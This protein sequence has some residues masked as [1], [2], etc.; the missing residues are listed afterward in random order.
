MK[1]KWGISVGLILSL[2]SVV[3]PCQLAAETALGEMILTGAATV[4]HVKA[5]S[6]STLFSGS[7]IET[8][9]PG[10]A[11]I[12][13]R[14]G[15]GVLALEPNS[16]VRLAGAPHRLTATV[17]QGLVTVRAKAPATVATPQLRIESE[18]ESA[19]QVAVTRERTEVVALTRTVRVRSNGTSVIVRPGERYNSQSGST[20][21]ATT[22]QDQSEASQRKRRVWGIL[23]PLLIG[24]I[25][26]PLAL[27]VADGEQSPAVSPTTPRARR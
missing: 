9:N 1:A 25:A 26:L 2:L 8:L 12:T 4:N 24:A 14:D 11:L 17:S 27:V 7:E 19:Y 20:T 16:R 10:A 18:A 5:T 3:L 15:A 13:L 21:P 22:P 6:G 23:M